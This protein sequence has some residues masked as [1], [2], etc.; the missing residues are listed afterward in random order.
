MIKKLACFPLFALALLALPTAA[1]A[2]TLQYNGNGQT[3][4][5]P[6]ASQTSDTS[7]VVA[8]S[9]MCKNGSQFAGWN[10][11]SDGS[12]AEYDPGDTFLPLSPAATQN[13]YATWSEDVG[14]TCANANVSVEVLGPAG[15]SVTSTPAGIDCPGAACLAEFPQGGT[16]TLQATPGT[17]SVFLGWSGSC[18]GT[19]GCVLASL[20]DAAEVQAL[21]SGTP[22]FSL[23]VD[24]AGSGWGTVTGKIG[25]SSILDCGALCQANVT[26]GSTVVL[27]A[28]PNDTSTFT[29]WSESSCDTSTCSLTVSEAKVV[30]ATFT[31][32][33][34]AQRIILQKVRPSASRKKKNQTLASVSCLRGSCEILGVSARAVGGNSRRDLQSTWSGD[35]FVSPEKQNISVRLPGAVG[36]N[37]A[38]RFVAISIVASSGTER[39]EKTLR[40]SLR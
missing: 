25:E 8:A 2:F 15:S 5:Q 21:F 31:A 12:G 9:T 34:M 37:K 13:L 27:E 22:A 35:P 39:V 18:T 4:G 16:V 23:A 29:S 6:P 1:E 36:R 17:G 38:F 10:S 26:Q 32:L 7:V 28:T 30:T 24:K 33:P 19:G 40:F 14:A 11:A 3:S 20:A